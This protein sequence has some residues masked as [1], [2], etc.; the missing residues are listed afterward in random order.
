[1][2]NNQNS[3]KSIR[4]QAINEP[5]TY[6]ELFQSHGFMSR[7]PTNTNNTQP[8]DPFEHLTIN[9]PTP[10]NNNIGFIN[11]PFQSNNANN[12]NTSQSNQIRPTSPPLNQTISTISTAP[13]RLPSPP[14][15]S[16]TPLPTP[17]INGLSRSSPLPSSPM[18]PPIPPP[19]VQPTATSSIAV[20]T[21]QGIN[22]HTQPQ[23]LV[24]EAI[25]ATYPTTNTSYNNPNAYNNSNTINRSRNIDTQS[26]STL[27]RS[28]SS[29]N[30]QGQLS[31]ENRSSSTVSDTYTQAIHKSTKLVNYINRTLYGEEVKDS[32]EDITIGTGASSSPDRPSP[33]GALNPNSPSNSTTS[34]SN[35]TTN[36]TLPIKRRQLLPL[37]L[38]E[39][40]DPSTGNTTIREIRL[41]LR[42]PKLTPTTNTTNTTSSTK[43]KSPQGKRSDIVVLGK[44]KATGQ[45]LKR[46][47]LVCR[48]L[49][50][51][52]S[53]AYVYVCILY[54]I[55]I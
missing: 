51:V 15:S 14:Q 6:D 35:T 13:I 19:T 20:P 45:D 8:I 12:T 50:V 55:R 24:V 49:V 33:S 52:Y 18:R 46:V 11:T 3:T 23:L 38:I 16:P 44:T 29:E 22:Y 40:R 4:I 27:K 39:L 54:L 5:P 37:Q 1:M 26:T 28:P 2:N 41:T 53:I 48:R 10:V 21:V 25:P 47:E 7:S 32:S 17:P 31:R 42:Q 43:H 9:T 30:Q 36:T 34:T